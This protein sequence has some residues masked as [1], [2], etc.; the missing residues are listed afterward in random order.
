MLDAYA[1]R[2]AIPRIVLAVIGIN[3]SIY[4]CIAA[5]DATNVVSGGM[6]QLLTRPFSDS[7]MTVFDVPTDPANSIVAGVGI[8]LGGKPLLAAAQKAFTAV[9][10]QG[11]SVVYSTLGSLL[12]LIIPIALLALSI[13]ITVVIRQAL[14]FLLIVIAPLA[15]ACYIL[16]GTEKYFRT[17]YD[18]FLKTLL[19]YPIIAV[20]FAL[21]DV[22]ASIIFSN[23]TGG[24]TG[25]A[26]IVTGIVVIYAPLFLIPFAFKFAGGALS[27]IAT[28]ATGIGERLAKSGPVKQRREYYAQKTQD[29]MTRGGAEAYRQAQKSYEKSSGFKRFRAGRRMSNLSGYKNDIYQREAAM[30]E[31]LA[32]EQEQQKNFGDDTDRRAY[33]IDRE[34]A[35]AD[36]AAS[37]AANTTTLSTINGK[38]YRTSQNGRLRQEVEL[39][40]SG[41]VKDVKGTTYR[42]LGG[43][44]QTKAASVAAD[45]RF[46]MNNTGQLQQTL[47]YEMGKAIETGQQEELIAQY[48]DLAQSWGL[49]S[50]Q[51]NGTWIGPAFNNQ[52]EDLMYKN[53]SFDAN[54][55]SKLD[56]G[57]M[58]REVYEKKGPQMLA[59]LKGKNIQE[60][61]AGHAD[62]VD[63]LNSSAVG[64]DDHTQAL[65]ELKMH[66]SIMDTLAAKGGAPMPTAGTG[67][68]SAASGPASPVIPTG[69][70]TAGTAGDTEYGWTV[71]SGHTTDEL[72][73]YFSE[74]QATTRERANNT[75]GGPI[76]N[77]LRNSTATPVN[78]IESQAAEADPT[79]N[80]PRL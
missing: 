50:E 64:S 29:A 18:L 45:R 34:A 46:G 39:D 80:R 25:V 11:I 79:R 60:M 73:Q 5:V 9:G 3:L 69:I 56:Y 54:G 21:S 76:R 57:K 68:P 48:G 36:M 28:A 70:P 13:V 53:T 40:S 71:G 30:N 6:A 75:T 8:A 41:N 4:L 47:T 23:N 43:S 26:Q 7:G 61:R 2:K 33:G 32:K 12:W 24:L 62:A 49:S 42:S 59:Y 17:W 16:P 66:E 65:T 35:E 14:L 22:F 55:A 15:I 31:R 67:A 52:Q 10:T 74:V 38:S 19:V 77:P 72:K 1:V 63:R 58:T 37:L 51:T 27:R 20:I 44:W 78:P